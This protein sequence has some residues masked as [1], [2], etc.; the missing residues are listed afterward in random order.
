[1]ILPFS[2]LELA[3]KNPAKFGKSYA[4][5]SGGF[6]SRNFRTFLSTAV[7]DFHHGATKDAVVKAFTKKCEDKLKL[8]AHFNARLKHYV[9]ILSD[10]CDL[11]ATQGCEFVEAKKATK[12]VIGTHL[13]RGKID[14]FDIRIAGGYRATM[15]QMEQSAWEG[16]VRW[17]LIQK[18]IAT[19]LGA[20]TDEVEVGVFSYADGTYA[21]RTFTDQEI[22]SAESEALTVLNQVEANMP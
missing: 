14:R 3:R 15:T 20:P 22:A 17:P 11:Y 1:M 4:P 16:E 18:G 13:L 7:K 6:N 5:G 2:Q 8:Q 21:Y 9:K 10:Y 19:E 12:L